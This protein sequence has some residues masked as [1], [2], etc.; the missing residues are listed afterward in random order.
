MNTFLTKEDK[1]NIMNLQQRFRK[2]KDFSLQEELQ[3]IMSK[4]SLLE[5]IVNDEILYKGN[6][7]GWRLDRQPVKVSFAKQE[8]P[9]VASYDLQ[10]KIRKITKSSQPDLDYLDCLKIW[11]HF[12]EKKVFICDKLKLCFGDDLDQADYLIMDFR[13]NTVIK[14]KKGKVEKGSIKNDQFRIYEKENHFP[15]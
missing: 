3:E 6:G 8:Q 2:E 7:K 5:R 10:R 13:K 11:G 14:Q 4:A 1:S 15:D 9:F 12:T